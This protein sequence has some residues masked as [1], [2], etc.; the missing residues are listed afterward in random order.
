[1][2]DILCYSCTVLIKPTRNVFPLHWSNNFL[3]KSH[4]VQFGKKLKARTLPTS[5][6]LSTTQNTCWAEIKLITEYRLKH[7]ELLGKGGLYK[8]FESL[9]Q[10]ASYMTDQAVLPLDLFDRGA[11]LCSV[12]HPGQGSRH[13]HPGQGR[14]GQ[15]S[16]H[17]HPGLGRHQHSA[18]LCPEGC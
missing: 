5:C 9:Q 8:A 3:E 11:G 18:H 2:Q 16:R 6:F 7:T 1:M 13:T 14:A 12:G 10:W 4:K 15:G 17:T